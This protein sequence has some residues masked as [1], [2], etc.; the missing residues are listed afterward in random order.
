MA[1]RWTSARSYQSLRGVT[2]PSV[3]RLTCDSVRA[4]SRVSPTQASIP[5]SIRWVVKAKDVH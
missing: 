3:S 4:L 5:V 2:I 1:A